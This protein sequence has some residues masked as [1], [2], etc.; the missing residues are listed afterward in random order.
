MERLGDLERAVMDIL[1]DNPDALPATKLRDELGRSA[2][3][4][5]GNVLALTTVLTVLSR[6]EAKGFVTRDRDIRPHRYQATG[7]RPDHMAELMHEVL[8]AARDREAV[9]ARFVG[10]VGPE[11]ASTLRRILDGL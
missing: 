7:S 4:N 10:R 6:L 1:W 11:E 8:G 2:T 9:L 5:S 3:V